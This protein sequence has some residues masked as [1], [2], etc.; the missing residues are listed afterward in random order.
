[1]KTMSEM[2]AQIT[3]LIDT[4]DTLEI[5]RDQ[6]AAI[7]SLEIQNQYAIAKS[8]QVKN[9]ADYNIPIYLENGRPYDVNGKDGKTLTR[10]VNILL[11]K[12]GV[13]ES[14]PRLGTQKER[15]TFFIDCAACGND[16]GNF[17]D[18][19][20]AMFRAWRVTRLVRRILMS[21]YYAY[22]GFRGIVSERTV[23]A[24]VAGNPDKL[25]D[26]ALFW[27]TI[28]V[29]FEVG[30][31]EKAIEA[32]GVLLDGIDFEVDPVSGELQATAGKTAEG[33]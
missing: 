6:I 17:R 3:E 26:S 1:M 7:L 32:Q 19:K 8:Q 29:T 30:F 15:A 2:Q 16:S 23:T 9:T 21:D 18:D 11:P 25:E 10:F 13:P 14:N 33:G 27:E 20:S 28:R 31:M 24:M 4:P 22:L 5:V 12:V